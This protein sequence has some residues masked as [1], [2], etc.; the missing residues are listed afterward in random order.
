ML[1]CSVAES[2]LRNARLGPVRVAT[3][4]VSIGVVAIDACLL[5]DAEE[6]GEVALQDVETLAVL[7]VEAD[8]AARTSVSLSQFETARAFT[9]Q[10]RAPSESQVSA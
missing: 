1:A 6:V 4:G 7:G 3:G 9:D 10:E 2:V 8:L 5:D